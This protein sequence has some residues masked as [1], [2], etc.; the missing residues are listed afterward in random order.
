[1]KY[2]LSVVFLGN[3]HSL[4]ATAAKLGIDIGDAKLIMET[5]KTS[6]DSLKALQ[7]RLNTAENMSV[8]FM[9]KALALL[10]QLGAHPTMKQKQQVLDSL[11][12]TDFA[13]QVSTGEVLGVMNLLGFSKDDVES[14]VSE[15]VTFLDSLS[16]ADMPALLTDLHGLLL[17]MGVP[18]GSLSAGIDMLE[19]K[20][21]E[22]LLYFYEAA[23]S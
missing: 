19:D 20:V 13:N 7:N 4:I 21:K 6:K 9:S 5:V 11:N 17:E 8:P 10:N 2:L 3:H 15:I 16:I 23:S 12:I 22:I 1:M 18:N 14:A